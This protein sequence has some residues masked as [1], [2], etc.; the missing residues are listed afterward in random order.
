MGT[1]STRGK[2]EAVDRLGLL[3]REAAA[4]ATQHGEGKTQG[5]TGT[6]AV[7]SQINTFLLQ[8]ANQGQAI[9]KHAG[10]GCNGILMSTLMIDM[11][12]IVRSRAKGKLS[13]LHHG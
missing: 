4:S 11:Q 7:S 8:R 1:M 12:L 9:E 2:G 13:G 5:G 6:G 10:S 3:L